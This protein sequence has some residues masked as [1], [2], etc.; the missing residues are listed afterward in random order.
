[1]K[2][3]VRESGVPTGL[4][5]VL[6]HAFPLSGEMWQPQRE[7]LKAFRVL[8]PDMRGFG[9]TPLVAPFLI[10]HLVDDIL[11]T[12]DELGVKKS[13]FVG[14]S[15]G[16]YAALRLAEKAPERVRALI[17]CDTRAE[18][19]GNEAK[20]KRAAT[21]EL[22]RSKGLAAFA[23]PFL[24]GALAPR[25]L[26]ASP[27]AVDFL[28]QMILRAQPEAVMHALAAL[29]ARTETLPALPSFRFPTL[30][31]V[32][33][34]DQLTPLSC[35]ETLRGRIVGSQLQIIPDAGH[36]TSVENPQAFNRAVSSF[37]AGLAPLGDRV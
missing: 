18:A 6:L 8:A 36:F 7:A 9:R 28:R 35:S 14:N 1:M 20:L 16:G 10:E 31:L 23:G 33:S 19:D 17:L 30:I 26:S 24:Q 15:M 32:G 4:P 5:V 12:L 11:E 34:Q 22:V 2:L 21:I 37:L 27:M 13:V 29:A 25:T 3:H